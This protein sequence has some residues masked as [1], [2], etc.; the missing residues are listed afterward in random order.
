MTAT[1]ELQLPL[2]PTLHSG[3]PGQEQTAANARCSYLNVTPVTCNPQQPELLSSCTENQ[4]CHRV[5]VLWGKTSIFYLVFAVFVHR[6][7]ISGIS[8]RF[9]AGAPSASKKS[10][11]GT[12]VYGCPFFLVAPAN[13][14]LM[15]AKYCFSTVRKCPRGGRRCLRMA[16]SR[17]KGSGS[18][19]E[20]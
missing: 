18:L 8:A 3:A 16:A 14:K 9:L 17:R 11:L 12:H 10:G 13:G 15:F 5:D 7:P 2:T 4:L 20:H 6:R 19:H 1:G